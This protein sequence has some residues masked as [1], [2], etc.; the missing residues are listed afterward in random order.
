M[1]SCILY[2]GSDGV[3][4]VCLFSRNAHRPRERLKFHHSVPTK[5]CFVIEHL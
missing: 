1:K 5:I 4:D 3:V 2:P